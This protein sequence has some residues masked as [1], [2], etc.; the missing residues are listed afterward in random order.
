MSALAGMVP[1]L[2]NGGIVRARSGGT[3]ALLGEAGRDEA[4]IPLGRGGNATSGNNYNITI[5]T[6]VG[7]SAEIGRELIRHLQSYEKRAGKLP[8]RTM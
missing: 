1:Q 4:V 5:Q 7:D 6:G 3:L 8:I 2:A